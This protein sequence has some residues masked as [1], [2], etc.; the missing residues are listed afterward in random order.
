M[1][2]FTSLPEIRSFVAQ[3]CFDNLETINNKLK[4]PPLSISPSWTKSGSWS[5]KSS[6]AMKNERIKSNITQIQIDDH[7]RFE[8]PV[9]I[10]S[11]LQQRSSL[12]TINQR[13]HHSPTK[14]V[15]KHRSNLSFCSD[16]IQQNS[17]KLYQKKNSFPHSISNYEVSSNQFFSQSTARYP[18]TPLLA[19]SRH[20]NIDKFDY[21]PS[22]IHMSPIAT[23]DDDDESD[24]ISS[25]SSFRSCIDSINE[26]SDMNTTESSSLL[27]KSFQELSSSYDLYPEIS[28]ETIKR[29]R[30]SVRHFCTVQ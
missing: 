26:F 13:N 30:S 7:S 15:N 4:L 6:N 16:Q 14:L 11:P 25:N 8:L 5:W 10:E 22:Q 21:H 20:M 27:E 1:S 2:P 12:Q 23:F 18:S 17:S 9:I 19:C 28:D 3:N 24:S 29:S